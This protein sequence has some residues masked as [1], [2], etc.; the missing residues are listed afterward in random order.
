MTQGRIRI[1]G[2]FLW[3]DIWKGVSTERLRDNDIDEFL[4]DDLHKAKL[5]TDDIKTYTW[6]VKDRKSVV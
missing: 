2:K 3:Y 6:I 4:L 1:D 5:T